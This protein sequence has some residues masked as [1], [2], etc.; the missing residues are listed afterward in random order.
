MA[1][2]LVSS[3]KST[4]Q[5]NAISLGGAWDSNSFVLH[6]KVLWFYIYHLL[7]LHFQCMHFILFDVTRVLFRDD[8]SVLGR[9]AIWPQLFVKGL[10]N[11]LCGCNRTTCVANLRLLLLLLLLTILNL[12]LVDSF[13]ASCIVLWDFTRCLFII[14]WQ[15]HG[16]DVV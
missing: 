9:A 1:L 8:F 2:I 14:V 15:Q 5:I 13:L 6:I 11:I 4:R 12:L 3:V 10:R 7:S 16:I